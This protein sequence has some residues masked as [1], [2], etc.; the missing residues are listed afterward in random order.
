MLGSDFCR[1]VRVR[2]TMYSWATHRCMRSLR[3]LMVFPAASS[4]M[5]SSISSSTHHRHNKR[6]IFGSMAAHSIRCRS[7]T[8]PSHESGTFLLGFCIGG[9]LPGFVPDFVS[10][11]Y[12]PIVPIFGSIRVLHFVL[13]ALSPRLN[14]PPY[15]SGVAPNRWLFFCDD[16]C[17]GVVYFFIRKSKKMM[18]S[19]S[20]SE[21]E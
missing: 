21:E 17:C 5:S 15:Q 19:K 1:V 14:R 8:F 20:C 11:R 16:F 10:V 18:S 13:R 12:S 6:M 4:T 3:M 7:S 2:S 9:L